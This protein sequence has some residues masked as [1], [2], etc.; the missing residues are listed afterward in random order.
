MTIHSLQI[1]GRASDKGLTL[2][3]ERF[4][5]LIR[6]IEKTREQRVELERR[7]QEFRQ[8]HSQKLHPLRAALSSTCRD[9]V[10]AVD[11]LLEQRGWSRWEISSLSGLLCDTAEALLAANPA[12]EELKALFRKHSRIDFDAAKEED[13]QRL[14]EHAEAYTGLDLGEGETFNSEEE[15]IQRV[16]EELAAREAA[17][18][19]QQEAKK[20]RRKKSAAQQ[21]SEDNALLARQSLREIYRR[22]ASALHP[23]READPARR[24]EKNALMQKINRA[25][26][27]NDL[28]TLFET[29]MQIEQIEAQQIGKASS[30]RIKQYNKLLAE[31]LA[32][33]KSALSE[34]ESGFRMDFG[35]PPRAEINAHTLHLFMQRQARHFRAEL[36]QQRQLLDVLSDK[37]A[38]KRWLK[39]QRRINE[40]FDLDDEDD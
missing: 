21:R 23:D 17:E 32:A 25:Y 34:L 10:F 8:T 30:A 28:L 18:Q 29:Q 33:A 4:N 11:R 1:S 9:S 14:K 35:L 6:E 26:A 38:T 22:L 36:T 13:L 12:D 27:A 16:Y 15:L 37:A 5:F 7:L 24:E 20:S 39:Q 40:R 2:E 31:Q 19:E 3:Q